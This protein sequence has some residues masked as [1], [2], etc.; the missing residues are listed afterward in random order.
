MMGFFFVVSIV[1][2]RELIDCGGLSTML[3]ETVADRII[4]CKYINIEETY[5]CCDVDHIVGRLCDLIVTNIVMHNHLPQNPD[6]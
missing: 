2:A 6:F 3:N 4:S 1:S 5:L